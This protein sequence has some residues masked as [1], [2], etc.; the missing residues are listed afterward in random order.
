MQMLGITFDMRSNQDFNINGLVPYKLISAAHLLYCCAHI[1]I[2]YVPTSKNKLFSSTL[3]LVV[4]VVIEAV[5]LHVVVL[6]LQLLYT[7]RR[8]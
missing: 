7:A 5:V 3:L 2:Q 8:E 6:F 4:V 1:D